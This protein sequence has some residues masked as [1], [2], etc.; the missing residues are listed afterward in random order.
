MGNR[1][2]D[3]NAT[4]GHNPSTIDYNGCFETADYEKE[5]QLYLGTFK[6]TSSTDSWT[7]NTISTTK[8]SASS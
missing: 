4:N 2:R 6:D 7:A 8:Y 1:V 3:V 5:S